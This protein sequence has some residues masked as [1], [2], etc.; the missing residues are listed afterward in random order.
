[1]WIA[2]WAPNGFLEVIGALML[3]HSRE[4]ESRAEAAFDA[5]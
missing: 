4:C 1:M 5:K 2:R 3:L